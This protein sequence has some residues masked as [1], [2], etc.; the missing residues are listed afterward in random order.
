M[1]HIYDL[2]EE[3]EQSNDIEL[4]YYDVGTPSVIIEEQQQYGIFLD[5][6]CIHTLSEE[7]VCLAHEI[8]H[9]QTGTTHSV[10]SPL[11]LVSKNEYKANKK[12]VHK[13][14][15]FSD[16]MKALDEGVIEVWE[17]AEYFEVTESFITLTLQ[18][19]QNEGRLPVQIHP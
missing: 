9:A 7:V 18:I 1:N 12:A 2:Y 17:L 8:S 11:Q 3:V 6:N 19:Y 10:Y 15:P 14:I 13:L 5:L 16:L 4:F